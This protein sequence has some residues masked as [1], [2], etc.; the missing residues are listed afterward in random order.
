[1]MIIGFLFLSFTFSISQK[2]CVWND[3]K[4]NNFDISPLKKNED[5]TLDLKSRDSEIFSKKIFFNF[6][7]NI[8]RKCKNSYSSAIEVLEVMGEETDDCSIIGNM[9]NSEISLIDDNNIGKGLKI[10]YNQGDKCINSENPTQ[11]NFPR[12]VT[13]ILYCSKIQDDKFSET[14]ID[15]NTIT[16]CNLVFTIKTPTGCPLG[17]KNLI[18]EENQ[19]SQLTNILLWG[20]V[21]FFIYLVLGSIINYAFFY[22]NGLNIIPNYDFWKS[23]LNYLTNLFEFFREKN[24]FKQSNKTNCPYEVV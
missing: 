20:I 3:G 12:K 18:P 1:M 10:I 16:K 21:V 24:V 5:W 2:S 11:N 23:L 7:K 4:G 6:C 14:L 15:S 13:F 17:W 19:K 8:T 22:K 9:K